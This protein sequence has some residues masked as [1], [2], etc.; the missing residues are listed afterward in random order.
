MSGLFEPKGE[1][2]RRELMIDVVNAHE[3]GDVLSYEFL[4]GALGV[5]SRRGVQSAVN[6]A[7]ASV[8]KVTSRS[9]VAEPKVGYRILNACEHYGRAVVHQRR[10]SRQLSRALSKVEN[11]RLSELSVDERAVVTSAVVTLRLQREWERRADLKYAR[12]D[13]VREMAER[14]LAVEERTDSEVAVLRERLERLERRL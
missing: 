6:G 9:L 1:K 5:G 12:A 8:E 14:Q 2:S 10:G 11:V 4:Q 7:K 3:P 13:E